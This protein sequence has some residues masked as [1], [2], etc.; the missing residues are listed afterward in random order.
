MRKKR[1]RLRNIIRILKFISVVFGIACVFLILGA[2]G[3]SDFETMVDST[4][5]HPLSYFI[6]LILLGFGFGFLSY[7]FNK[8]S[9]Y[10]EYWR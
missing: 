10:L 1:R 8:V 5:M 4:V 9:T 6:K 2:A 3:Q 7:I